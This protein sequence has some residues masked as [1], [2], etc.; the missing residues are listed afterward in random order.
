MPLRPLA[1]AIV[2]AALSLPAA[3]VPLLAQPAAAQPA[4]A[5]APDAVP[6]EIV[7]GSATAP[8]RGAAC[9][10]ARKDAR[11][12]SGKPPRSLGECRCQQ[13]LGRNGQWH[14]T[15]AGVSR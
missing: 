1:A 12:E 2:L 3:S 7:T 15:V 14:C 6:G 8:D 11:S 4:Q 5:P 9:E 10:A 13:F